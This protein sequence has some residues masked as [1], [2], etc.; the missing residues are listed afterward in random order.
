MEGSVDED[1]TKL[2]EEY[3]DLVMQDEHNNGCWSDVESD[4]KPLLDE[5]YTSVKDE[6]NQL[7]KHRDP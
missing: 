6:K 5:N 2:D 4:G 3:E 1:A 7:D